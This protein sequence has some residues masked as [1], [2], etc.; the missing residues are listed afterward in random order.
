MRYALPGWSLAVRPVDRIAALVVLTGTD[1]CTG[2]AGELAPYR[3]V[4]GR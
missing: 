3:L 1:G 2:R 4:G